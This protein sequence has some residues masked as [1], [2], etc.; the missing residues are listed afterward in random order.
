MNTNRLNSRSDK[1]VAVFLFALGG[2]LIGLTPP[3]SALVVSST[4]PAE[5]CDQDEL[6][7]ENRQLREQVARQQADIAALQAKL[8]ATQQ[9]IAQLSAAQQV[10]EQANAAKNA[11]LEQ[12]NQVIE[13]QAN[14]LAQLQAKVADLS[15]SLIAEKA[16]RRRAMDN[17][18]RAREQ[19]KALLQQLAELK[20]AAPPRDRAPA[21]PAPEPEDG[22]VI[23][24]SV[25]KVDQIDGGLVFVQL[26]VGSDDAVLPGMAFTVY[27]GDQ[28]V[29]KVKIDTVDATESVGRLTLGEGV[30]AG[31]KVR[32]G[33]R[34]KPVKPENA[35]KLEDAEQAGPPAGQG[36]N[37]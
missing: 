9:T 19:N 36:P 32:A 5:V 11:R 10:V 7:A 34:G 14:D 26:N 31:D 27:R 6:A 3:V 2:T 22:V 35:E 37:E 29:G 15:Q 16:E 33:R 28:F 8:T 1:L 24:G 23:R 12:Q 25:V 21:P 13:Q 4:Q 17:F 30:K 20:A 18:T